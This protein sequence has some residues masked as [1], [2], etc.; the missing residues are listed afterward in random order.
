[1]IAAT[2]VQ[3]LVQPV[4]DYPAAS[5]RLRETGTVVVHVLIG[6]DGTAQRSARAPVLGLCAARRRRAGRPSA[7]RGSGR[8]TENGQAVEVWAPMPIDFELER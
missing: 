4:P 2:S 7:R 1:M 8:Y 6:E 5:I 3:Y